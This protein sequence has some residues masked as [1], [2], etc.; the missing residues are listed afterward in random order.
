MSTLQENVLVNLINKGVVD[1]GELR[2][3]KTSLGVKRRGERYLI[4]LPINRN[5]LWKVLHDKKIKVR[6]YIEIPIEALANEA[7]KR[8]A[9]S[10]REEA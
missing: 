3:S 4:Y 7:R 9:E 6:I 2:I 8:E 10:E 5:Y 1:V